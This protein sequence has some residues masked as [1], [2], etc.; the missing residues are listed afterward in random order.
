MKSALDIFSPDL[1]VDG[2]PHE[3]FAVLRREAPVAWQSE[4]DGPG[5][6]AITKHADVFRVLKDTATFSSAAGG[7]L[8]QDLPES[9]IRRAPDNLIAM[10]PPRHTQYR[11]LINQSFTSRGLKQMEGYS[12]RLV[13]SLL[14]ELIERRRFDFVQDFAAKLPAAIILTM[15]GV[16]QQDQPLVSGWVWQLLAPDDPEFA[17]SEQARAETGKAF[18]QYAHEL[19]AERR[20]SPRDDLLSLLMAAEVDGVK[21]SYQEFGTFFILLLA[22][23]T[24]TP[25]LAL[26]SA[27]L[28]LLKNPEQHALL[29]REPRLLASAVEESLRYEPPLMHFRRTA[30]R[31]VE[32]RGQRIRAG[33]KVVVWTVSAN[34]DE[35]AFVN[36]ERFDIQRSP[37]DHISFGHGPHFCI[38]NALARSTVRIALGECLRRMPELGLAGPVERL[39]SNW[40]NG[41]KHMPVSVDANRSEPRG[42][43]AGDN[44]NKL[45]NSAARDERSLS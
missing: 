30:T 41:L 34:R 2:V 38:G 40:F 27:L 44:G 1:Y 7:T 28:A 14:D 29:R 35:E 16:P 36:P 11:A 13:T 19:A 43:R 10:D 9:D 26:C 17:S 24:D 32:I 42:T 21:L 22:A 5:F 23:G 39:R 8:V 20:E 45:S 4:P 25:Q 31:E 37:N 18:M 12:E 15:V 6:W 33:E 3:R